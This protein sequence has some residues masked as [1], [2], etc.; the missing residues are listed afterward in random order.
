MFCGDYTQTDLTKD[1]DKKGILR[2]MEV[3]SYIKE[4]TSVEFMVDDIVRSDFLKSYI[5]AKYK[6]G[7]NG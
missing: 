6:L 3:L 1:N 4:F 7:I 5:I 2:F